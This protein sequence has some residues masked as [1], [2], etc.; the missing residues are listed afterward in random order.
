ML[1]HS[2]DHSGLDKQL[3]T[4]DWNVGLHAAVSIRVGET[5]PW[6]GSA[7]HLQES[8]QSAQVP[9]PS[10]SKLTVSSRFWTPEWSCTFRFSNA[11]QLYQ[12]YVGLSLSSVHYQ[13][14]DRKNLY[15]FAWTHCFGQLGLNLGTYISPLGVV[16][17]HVYRY[18]YI[19][20]YC[21][22]YLIDVHFCSSLMVPMALW[23]NT[24]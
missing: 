7:S 6:P 15:A 12:L 22:L 3:T 24:L 5:T 19:Y 14:L 13:R 8:L 18:M 4:S 1:G 2:F 16:D 10:G 23:F 20:I 17:I 11:G 21:F 9:A